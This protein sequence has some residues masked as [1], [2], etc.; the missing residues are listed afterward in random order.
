MEGINPDL[1]KV[2]DRALELSLYDFMITDGKRTIEEQRH[3]VSIGASQTM[4]SNH[5][6]GHAIDFAILINGKVRW[7]FPLYE[8]VSR[9]FKQAA[10]ELGVKII[11]GGDWKRFKDG[12]HIELNRR[13]YV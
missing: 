7:E 12:P 6:T 9:A 3:Y 1:R 4:S 5:L 10:K 2:C 13:Y 8:E 11:W